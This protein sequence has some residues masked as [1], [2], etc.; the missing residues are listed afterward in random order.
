M[1][2]FI[3]EA[4][5]VIIA[6]LILGCT[7]GF[8]FAAVCTAQMYNILEMPFKMVTPWPLI[9]IMVFLALLTTFFA[10]YIPVSRLNKCKISD[11]IKGLTEVTEE[12]ELDQSVNYRYRQLRN[13]R[14]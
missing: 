14:I 12:P 5:A 13:I 7:C 3:Y 2:I 6:S 11:I 4:Y 1:R 9:L 8:V 10:V